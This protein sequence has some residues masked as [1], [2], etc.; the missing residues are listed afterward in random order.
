MRAHVQFVLMV[1]CKLRLE[2]IMSFAFRC[3]LIGSSVRGRECA[4]G[5]EVVA[6]QHTR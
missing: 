4:W 6:L 3:T 5:E 1:Q 2:T